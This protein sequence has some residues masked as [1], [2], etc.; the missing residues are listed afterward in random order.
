MEVFPLFSLVHRSVDNVDFVNSIAQA[1]HR[2]G[3]A[4]FC[5]IGRGYGVTQVA[6]LTLAHL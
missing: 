3:Y 1:K 4:R 5:K 6:L 2:S